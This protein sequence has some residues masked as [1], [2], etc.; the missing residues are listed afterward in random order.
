M[1]KLPQP[2][3]KVI[4]TIKIAGFEAYA[5]GGSVRDLMMGRATKGWDFTTNAKPEEILKLFPDSFYDNQFGTVG[6]KIK[7]PED[8][9]EITPFRKEGSYTDHRHP[10]KIVWGKTIEDDLSRRDFTINSIA[11]DGKNLIDPFD[12]QKDIESK[13]IRAVGKATDRFAEDALRMM[14]AVRIA[15]QLGFMIDPATTDAIRAN[16]QLLITISAERIHDELVK[17]MASPYPA[18]GILLMRNTGVLKIILPELDV[19]FDTPQKS[20]QRHHIYDVGTHSVMALKFCPSTDPVVRFATLLHDIGKV[21]TFRQDASGLI[22]FYNHE[23]VS[24]KLTRNILERL[25]FSKKDSEK[26]LTLVRWHQFSVDERQT[27]SALRRFIRRVGKENLKDILDLRIGD[28]LGGGATETSWRLE[29]Y[30]KRLEEVQKQP[31]TVA[32]L[33]V[34]GHDV[35]S[36]FGIKPGPQVGKVLN[37]LFAEVEAGT[38]PN[39]RDA[40]LMKMKELKMTIS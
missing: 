34:D 31:F 16:V 21:K 13:L 27:D 24:T 28:R 5:V 10:D 14:R 32:D 2:A 38:L 39:D 4:D 22:T 17:L 29:L 6:V 36:E 25:R 33:K 37:E 19:A 18:D 35:M 1:I 9:Y 20:P 8:V 7:D 26:I 23:V 40:L 15:A 3:Q 11:Y 30:K 12:G